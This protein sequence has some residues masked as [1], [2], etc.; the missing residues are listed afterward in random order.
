MTRETIE[1]LNRNTLIGYTDKRGMAW[2]YREGG[3]NHFPGAVPAD[4][5]LQLFNWTAEESDITYDVVLDN[6]QRGT[7]VDRERKLYYRSDNGAALGVHG[8]GHQRHQYIEWLMNNVQILL[9]GELHIGQAGLLKGGAV[10]WV[11]I[12]MADTLTFSGVD[13]RPQLLAATS[14]DASLKSTNKLVSTIAVC[15]NTMAMALGEHSPTYAVAHTSKSKFDE[16]KARDALGLVEAYGE[17]FGRKLDELVGSKVTD[18]QFDRFLQIWIPM[19]EDKGAARTN[20]TAKQNR[21]TELWNSDP[22]VSPWHGTQFGVLQA[23]NT[24]HHHDTRVL[25]SV[26]DRGERNMLRAVTA[27]KSDSIET[28]DANVLQA[29]GLV[30]S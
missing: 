10:A 27:N 6:G 16:E 26:A 18:E 5:V 7:V 3:S 20:A 14:F 23:A 13:I 30:L 4:R 15:D 11:S 8:K 24:Y 29:L 12:E 1:D 21:Y 28:F 17:A 25:G 9:G 2:H 22:R 19:P